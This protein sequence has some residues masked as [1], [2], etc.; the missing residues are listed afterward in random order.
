MIESEKQATIEQRAAAI[1]Y[2]VARYRAHWNENQMTILH[3]R[4][5]ANQSA[6]ARRLLGIE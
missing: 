2:E 6:Y 3:Q 5:A 1:E 4:M